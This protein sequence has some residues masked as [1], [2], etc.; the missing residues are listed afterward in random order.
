[1]LLRRHLTIVV[2]VVW[3]LG[4]TSACRRIPIPVPLLASAIHAILA[5]WVLQDCHVIWLSKSYTA[6]IFKP[7]SRGVF[8]LLSLVNCW[9]PS[10]RALGTR[11]VS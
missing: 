10:P 11:F 1:M 5:G 6:R 3:E 7:G 9:I 4:G 8:A 2:I